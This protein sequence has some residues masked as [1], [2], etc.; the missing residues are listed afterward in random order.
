MRRLARNPIQFDVFEAFAG[1]GHQQ[2]VSIYKPEATEMFVNSV[3][4][5]IERALKNQAFLHGQRTQAMFEALVAS[6]GRVSLLKQED[7]GE[8]Y[9]SEERLEVPDFRVVLADGSQSLIEVKNFYQAQRPEAPF[10]MTEA[11]S[12]GLLRYAALMRCDLRIAT[13]WAGWNLWT[14]VPVTAF[15]QEGDRR[16]INLIDALKANEMALLGDLAVGTKFPLCL[17]V[18]ADKRAP[19]LLNEEGKATFTISQVEL[20]CGGQ[21]ISDDLDRR[22]AS[23]L[24]FYGKWI[25]E[26]PRVHLDD[27]KIDSIDI[28]VGPDED[29]GQGF[30]IVGW[31]SGM[32]SRFYAQATEGEG[33]IGQ[34]RAD[35]TPGALG[36][37]IPEGYTG[38]DLPL[39]VFVLKPM[40]PDESMP[41][42]NR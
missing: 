38:K 41:H 1:H 16:L 4:T 32:F 25:E 7:A 24:M 23:Y 30:E 6:L 26:E 37:L 33:Q 10:E 11:Y 13:Y 29:Q 3:R 5:S 18:I 40:L 15:R 27:G 36:S 21:R 22:I 42:E 34:I 9:T 17:K 8:V 19:R 14:L 31:L 28:C 35:I 20:Y 2:K 12:D 39:W